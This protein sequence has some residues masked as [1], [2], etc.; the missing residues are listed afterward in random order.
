MPRKDGRKETLLRE[1][2]AD[3]ISKES[4]RTSLI[5]VTGARFL[6]EGNRAEVM[7]TV[8]PDNQQAAALDFLNR[9]KE[10]FRDYLKKHAAFKRLPFVS[11]AL[12][13][14]EKHRQRIDE[15]SEDL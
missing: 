13:I 4:N 14:G 12:D 8:L 9:H 1:C 15:L 6:S 5:T 7:V 10:G 11:F 2:A 3:Y